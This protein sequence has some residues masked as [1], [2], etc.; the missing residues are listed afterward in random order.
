MRTRP[1]R[2]EPKVFRADHPFLYFIVD[3]KSGAILF[4]G[5][6]SDPR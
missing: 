6:M 3:K 5:R 2:E 4:M 1:E